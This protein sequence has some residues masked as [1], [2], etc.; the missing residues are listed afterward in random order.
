MA[1]DD[2]LDFAKLATTDVVRHIPFENYRTDDLHDQPKDV[3][4]AGSHLGCHKATRWI[5][6]AMQREGMA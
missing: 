4:A 2:V 5:Y 1:D 3:L 6:E